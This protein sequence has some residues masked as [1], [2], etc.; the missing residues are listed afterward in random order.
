MATAQV[1]RAVE[2]RSATTRS[3]T[4]KSAF[5][6]FQRAKDSDRI[7]DSDTG[8]KPLWTPSRGVPD[9]KGGHVTNHIRKRERNEDAQRPRLY[10][11]DDA[12]TIPF[13]RE[14]LVEPGTSKVPR[15]N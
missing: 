15:Y 12:P 3:E 7:P 5:R 9:E 10:I 11:D 1:S 4:S 13:E 8:P 14:P 2:F 6:E